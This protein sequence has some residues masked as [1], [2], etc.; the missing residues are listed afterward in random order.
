MNLIKPQKDK[1]SLESYITPSIRLSQN[2]IEKICQICNIAWKTYF[3]KPLPGYNDIK[4]YWKGK[5]QPFH[6]LNIDDQIE[7]IKSAHISNITDQDI[8]KQKNESKT[9]YEKFIS[10]FIGINE[11]NL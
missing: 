5:I 1:N 2:D 10:D 11:G 9:N 6:L 8:E 3:C 4:V 7:I